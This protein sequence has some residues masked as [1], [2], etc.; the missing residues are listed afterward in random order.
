MPLSIGISANCR[1]SSRRLHHRA[2]S[3]NI[4]KGFRGWLAADKGF[5]FAAPD[6]VALTD[7]D[8]H[9]FISG[10]ALQRSNI[11][12]LDRDDRISFVREP[13]RKRAG[14]FECQQIELIERAA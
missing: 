13:S 6:G 1:A 2:E 7:R 4:L 10:S 11:A 3:A 9:L 14:K 5:G 8:R 12:T